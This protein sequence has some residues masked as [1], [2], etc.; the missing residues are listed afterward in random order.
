[1]HRCARVLAI[2]TFAIN[3]F[4]HYATLRSHTTYMTARNVTVPTL[5]R[6]NQFCSTVFSHVC[7]YAILLIILLEFFPNLYA[8][9]FCLIAEWQIMK[10]MKH[11]SIT[12]V[13]ML[14][15]YH[16]MV[17]NFHVIKAYLAY[18]GL[19]QVF[20]DELLNIKYEWLILH[21]CWQLSSV[22]YQAHLWTLVGVAGPGWLD[23]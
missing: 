9:L 21:I 18:L 19:Q 10:T 5:M 23:E 1:M 12:Q 3:Y 7:N 14:L 11:L 4:F 2:F 16:V 22:L 17:H 20:L 13:A 8:S 6:Y 15:H